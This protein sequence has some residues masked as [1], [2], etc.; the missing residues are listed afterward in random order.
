M[1]MKK[2]IG[3]LAAIG[4]AA[5][6]ASCSPSGYSLYL[7]TRQPSVSGMKLTGKSIAVAW[8][9]DEARKDTV[10]SSNLAEGFAETLEADYFGGETAVDIYRMPKDPSGKYSDR[11]TLFNILMDSGK[12]VVFLLDAPTFGDVSI[13]GKTI[14]G[15]DKPDSS[16]LCYGSA[17]YSI[18]MY[19]YDS[20]AADSVRT[21]K[22]SSVVRVPIYCS[23]WTG[24]EALLHTFWRGLGAEGTR[25]GRK[26]ADTFLSQWK[27]EQ[28]T[29]IYYDDEQWT[30]ALL[31][32]EN[33]EWREA[34]D[35][36]MGQLGTK[37]MVKRSCAEYNLALAC[38]LLGDYS[39]AVSWLDLS[40]KDQYISLSAAL[41]KRIEDARK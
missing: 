17:P 4:T 29:L 28:F 14:V 37:N 15:G 39:L 7:Q 19:V 36:W 9:E 21:F 26:S 18:K 25:A 10:F 13:S 12:D 27:D 2:S 11:D 31:K 35:I 24:R 1:N 5:L 40:D 41:R 32:A 22:G 16:R 8:L 3:I 34:M 33:M 20:M 30:E 6:L 38:Y 23:E